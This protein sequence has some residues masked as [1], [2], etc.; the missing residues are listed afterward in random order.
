MFFFVSQ[1]AESINDFVWHERRVAI[2]NTTVL[3]VVVALAAL[4]VVG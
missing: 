2:T 1:N 3:V 4:D